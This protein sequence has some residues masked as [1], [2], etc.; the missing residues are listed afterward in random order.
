MDWDVAEIEN[1]SLRWY[2]RAAVRAHRQ[3]DIQHFYSVRAASTA[4][5]MMR[6]KCI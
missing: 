4:L 6:T 2:E 1:T 5:L 3:M